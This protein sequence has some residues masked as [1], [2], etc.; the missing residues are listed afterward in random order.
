M[1]PYPLTM[2]GLI[3]GNTPLST[4]YPAEFGRSRSSDTS[5]IKIHLKNLTPRVPTTES[6]KVIGTDTDRSAAYD[7]P[8]TFHSN[9]GPMSY[10]RTVSE[11]N[12][13]FSQTIAN[14]LSGFLL[15]L[16]KTG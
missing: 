7:V 14:P 5:V 12:G 8:L 16:G 9:Y 1:G 11:I 13:N 4:Y 6:L 15:E 2:G 3:P 10:G